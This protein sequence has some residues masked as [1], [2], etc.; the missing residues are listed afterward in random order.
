MSQGAWQGLLD[1]HRQASTTLASAAA[2]SHQDSQRWAACAAAPVGME[3]DPRARSPQRRQRSPDPSSMDSPWRRGGDEPYENV[4]F[5]SDGGFHASE[6]EI[7]QIAAS[8][9][10]EVTNEVLNPEVQDFGCGPLNRG[11]LG[12]SRAPSPDPDGA[13]R[14][15]RLGVDVTTGVHVSR[16][17]RT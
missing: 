13:S 5:D 10:V 2:V 11:L 6:T 9:S 12:C 15:A 17:L 3:A 14:S 16:K 4:D 7:E 8:D 1:M